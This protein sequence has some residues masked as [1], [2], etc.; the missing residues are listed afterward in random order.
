MTD[1]RYPYT[2]AA[3]YVRSFVTDFDERL[4]MKN[5]TMS[6]SQASQ[7]LKAF[8]TALGMPKEELARKLADAFLAAGSTGQ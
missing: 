2:H 5:T 4:G 6:R 1:S 8:A 3:D 7:A